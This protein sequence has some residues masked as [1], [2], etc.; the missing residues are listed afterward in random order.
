MNKEENVINEENSQLGGVN[1]QGPVVSEIQSTNVTSGLV[2]IQPNMQQSMPII[3]PNVSVPPVEISPV[4]MA[5]G[6]AQETQTNNAPSIPFQAEMPIPVPLDTIVVLVQPEIVS[7]MLVPNVVGAPIPEIISNNKKQK[8]YKG[9]FIILGIL[10]IL[11]VAVLIYFLVLKKDE[12]EPNDNSNSNSSSNSNSNTNTGSGYEWNP[13]TSKIKEINDVD[14]I[15]LICKKTAEID[16]IISGTTVKYIYKDG[17]FIQAII[18]DEITFNENSIKYYEFYLGS[19]EDEI[20]TETKYDNMITEIQK[21]KMSI[22]Y[23]YS[24]DMTADPTNPNNLLTSKSLTYES[25]KTQLKN[26]GYICE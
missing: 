9:L 3:E 1:I 10:L 22:S 14:A 25:A 2:P 11:V 12:K 15:K 16:E 23:V 7:P 4:Q 26:E 5:P 21:K 20:L 24:V 18:D 8:N 19:A 17:V 6:L 13:A